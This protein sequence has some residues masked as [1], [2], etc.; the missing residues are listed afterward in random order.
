MISSLG[1]DHNLVSLDH[2]SQLPTLFHGWAPN[3]ALVRLCVCR[4]CVLTSKEKNLWAYDGY[5][6]FSEW[7]F[8]MWFPS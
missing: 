7:Y 5:V 6:S 1:Q 4:E 2:S 3:A 8:K